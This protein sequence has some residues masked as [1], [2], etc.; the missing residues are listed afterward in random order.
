MHFEISA[1]FVQSEPNFRIF[2]RNFIQKHNKNQEK[3]NFRILSKKYFKT[4]KTH[5][6]SCYSLETIFLMTG[7][8]F[9]M[10]GKWPGIIFV[11]ENGHPGNINRNL[12]LIKIYLLNDK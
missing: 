2:T 7:K 5:C 3:F 6:I 8:K 1:L 12:Q 10:T 4:L 11:D 9:S